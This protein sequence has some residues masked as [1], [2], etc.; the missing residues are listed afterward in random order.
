MRVFSSYFALLSLRI[1]LHVWLPA[2]RFRPAMT[3][4][5][6]IVA[7]RDAITL[8]PAIINHIRNTLRGAPPVVLSPGEAAD[9]PLSTP[10]G[11]ELLEAALEGRPIDA[12]TVKTRARQKALLLAD[13]DST[14][15]TGETLDEL[16]AFAGIGEQIAAIT[17]RAMNG[18]L[19]FK[20]ALRE[21]VAM[22]KGLNID[23]MEKAWQRIQMT[24][25]AQELVATMRAR[26]ALTALVS[27]GFSYFTGKV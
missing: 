24:P 25:G 20:Q 1:R 5:T 8:T 3:Y 10:P 12:I 18:E 2:V 27:G 16:A 15:V 4:V 19:D 7:R 9:I 22:L 17:R 26:G 13:M 21:R 23:A 11:P 6:T 14:I